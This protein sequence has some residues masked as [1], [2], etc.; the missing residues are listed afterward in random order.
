[1]EV[2][3]KFC[4]L[5]E[6]YKYPDKVRYFYDHRVDPVVE[7]YVCWD[8]IT[9]LM[10]EAVQIKRPTNREGQNPTRGSLNYP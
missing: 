7:M 9:N 6:I 8:C 5:C 3:F 10:L 1:M 4:E 2:K